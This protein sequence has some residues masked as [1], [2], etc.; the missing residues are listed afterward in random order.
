MIVKNTR[1][2]AENKKTLKSNCPQYNWAHIH[3]IE[4]QN[5]TS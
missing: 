4:M 1:I 3:G 2:T 5:K